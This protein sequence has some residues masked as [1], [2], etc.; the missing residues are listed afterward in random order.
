T[1]RTVGEPRLRTISEPLRM[2]PGGATGSATIQTDKADYPPNTNVTVTGSGWQGGEAISLRF[3]E[4]P[5]IDGPHVFITVA[6]G[7]GN[8][9][10]GQFWP[11]LFDTALTF[12]VT[13]TGQF[14]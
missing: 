6:D 9:V 1:Q 10:D 12:P 11:D 13:A 7:N 4:Q 2:A 5:N 14:S 8:F 3:D